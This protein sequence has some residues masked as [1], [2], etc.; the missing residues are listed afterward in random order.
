MTTLWQDARFALRLIVGR[1]G[2]SLIVIL[3]LA[4]GIGANTA[5]FSVVNGVLLQPLSFREPDRLLRIWEKSKEF[6]IRREFGGLSQFPKLAGTQN[7]SFKRMAFRPQDYALTGI[8]LPEQV[9]GYQVSSQFFSAL[10]AAA[11]VRR[12][13]KQG[14]DQAGVPLAISEAKRANP[15]R[16]AR[17]RADILGGTQAV[18]ETL[19][20]KASTS[21][22]AYKTPSYGP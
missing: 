19:R 1:P 11:A 3:A 14:E 20:L 6:E 8:D 17:G 12:D 16:Y 4:L 15:Q 22:V 5:I 10:G 21:P 18:S 2:F 9:N 7:T 13:F